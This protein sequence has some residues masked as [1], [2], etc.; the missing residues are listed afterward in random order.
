MRWNPSM[1]NPKPRAAKLA[2]SPA[3]SAAPLK[4][5]HYAAGQLLSAADF[6]AEQDYF[7]EKLRRH[8]RLLHG[9]GVVSGL[10]VS[11]AGGSV[12]VAPGWALDALGNEVG[13]PAAAPL[14]LPRDGSAL[15]VVL[16]CAERLTDPAPVA[17][18]PGTVASRIEE[19]FALALEPERSGRSRGGVV[20]PEGVPLA[21]LFRFRGRWTVDS[22]FRAV[23]AR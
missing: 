18:G 23:R 7:L 5:V 21:R 4:R 6:R 13:V 16:R 9:W 15:L 11:L 19:T 22:R 2:P 20:V 3:V 14:A 8:N 1:S 12:V 10:S 17:S